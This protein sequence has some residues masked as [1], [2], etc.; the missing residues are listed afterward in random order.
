MLQPDSLTVT[1]HDAGGAVARDSG[2]ITVPDA[3]LLFSGDFKRAGS[4]LV[5]SDHEHEFV[6]HDY[7]RGRPILLSP[8]GAQLTPDIVDAL[9]GY[10]AYAQ[11]GAA[12]AAAE[13]VG[14]VAKVDGTAL[15]I[16]NGVA[17]TVNPGDAVFKGDMLQ[18]GA[19]TL[20]V[21]FLDGSTLNLT[22]NSRLLINDFV[23]EANGSSNSELLN[24]VQGSLSFISGE[25][26]HTGGNMHIKT[27]VATLGIRGT[28]GGI[29]EADDGSVKFYVVESAVGAVLL[30]NSGRVIAQVVQDGPTIHVLQTGVTQELT[31]SPQELALELA[32]LQQVLNTQ[33][34]GKQI[35]QQ[36][37]QNGAPHSTGT[38]HTQIEIDIPKSALA[39]PGS[40]GG[41]AGGG[42]PTSNSATV[43]TTTTDDNGNTTKTH[44]DVLFP[45]NPPPAASATTVYWTGA[46]G[47]DN[48]G[49]SANWTPSQAPTTTD[50]AIIGRDQ[51]NNPVADQTVNASD[52]VSVHALA[53]FDGAHLHADDVSTSGDIALFGDGSRTTEIVGGLTIHDVG[54][55][56]S[57]LATTSDA[58]IGSTDDLVIGNIAGDLTIQAAIPADQ[59]WSARA[60]IHAA[61][62][63]LTIGD[64]GGNFLLSATTEGDGAARAEITGGNVSIGD[65]GHDFTIEGSADPCS[66]A[67]AQISACGDLT[68][69]NRDGDF[70]IAGDFSNDGR[71]SALNGTLMIGKVGGS[72]VNAGDMIAHELHIASN[73]GEVLDNQGNLVVDGCNDCASTVGVDVDNTGQIKATHDA[74]L[75]LN[76][77]VH[78]SY[79]STVLATHC[80]EIDFNGATDNN[81][82]IRATQDGIVDFA[83]WVSG[84]G[85][86]AVDGGTIELASGTSNTVDFSSDCG[87]T[88][89]LDCATAPSGQIVGFGPDDS[90]GLANLNDVSIVGYTAD[91]DNSGVLHLYSCSTGNFCLSFTGDCTNYTA[92]NFILSCDHNGGT[93][94]TEGPV[95]LGNDQ[96]IADAPNDG[97]TITGLAVLEP[98]SADD[99]ITVNAQAGYGVMSFAQ[100]EPCVSSE[101]EEDGSFQFSGTLDAINHVLSDGVT[102]T[103]NAQPSTDMVTLNISNQQGATDVEHFVFSVHN[104]NDCPVTLTG[105]CGKDFIYDTESQDTMTGNG[106]SDTFIFHANSGTGDKITDFGY[107]DAILFSN[108]NGNTEY[109][110]KDATGA[111]N[112]YSALSADSHGDAVVT[113]ANNNAAVTLEDVN[114]QALACYLQSHFQVAA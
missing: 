35:I 49:N 14:R 9:T 17:I 30:D 96:Q 25:V 6:V 36:F 65:V 105:T 63:A 10:R 76:G 99:T 2:A 110:A 93:T 20:G 34:I 75:E 13:A 37:F 70:L 47:D 112:L 68:I 80:A 3:H 92:D 46:G 83:H 54:G 24:L 88:L 61:G 23:Y 66:S 69:G 11:A 15:I 42:T 29:T 43:T 108:D 12:P 73:A 94:I 71:I 91:S 31:K 57:L 27:P 50:N 53:L 33:T 86:L 62:A 64:I 111:Q 72:F 67:F 51:D 78:N 82:L 8:G 89:V 4:D 102:Y 107:D 56:L 97:T 114:E 98:F 106:G 52:P 44:Q 55:N 1:S 38:D 113:F 95:L 109:S 39:D 100:S 40:G 48:P 58:R 60:E 26:A 21:T 87:G 5:L 79:C 90:I 19:G 85:T 7:F 81:G 16:R 22:A 103:P 32:I 104:P 77:D 45:S 28:V 74:W 18:T 41:G 101:Q 84:N 59:S